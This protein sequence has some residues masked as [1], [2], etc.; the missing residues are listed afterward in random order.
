MAIG[1]GA[2][3]EEVRG[4][5]AEA[6]EDVVGSVELAVVAG[7]TDP[8]MDVTALADSG[9]IRAVEDRTRLES[10]AV[11]FSSAEA[12]GVINNLPKALE[13]LVGSEQA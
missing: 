9:G 6:I 4:T 13:G 10:V 3:V 1:S 11:L 2:S 8:A 7:D 12:L 5:V